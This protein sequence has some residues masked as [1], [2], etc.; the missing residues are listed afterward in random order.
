MTLSENPFMNLPPEETETS[1]EIVVTG[2]TCGDP[3]CTRAHRPEG[4]VAPGSHYSSDQSERA[5]EMIADGKMGGQFGHL[6]G[7]RGT[8]RSKRAAEIV[9]E[10]AVTA[11]EKIKRAFEDGLDEGNS[12]GVRQATALHLLNIERGEHE[13]QLKEQQQEFNQ[14]SKAD[15]IE[16]IRADFQALVGASNETDE[17]TDATVVEE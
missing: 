15:L 14:M 11:S 17:I 2:P 12:I 16:S 3:T 10:Y 9:A 8:K 6:S 13:L 7:G 1:Q 4:S 5:K